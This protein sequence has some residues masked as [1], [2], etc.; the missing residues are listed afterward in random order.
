MVC[1]L[2]SGKQVNYGESSKGFERHYSEGIRVP[3]LLG[4]HGTTYSSCLQQ[5]T[6]CLLRMFA[7]TYSMSDVQIENH[8]NQKCSPGEHCEETR[9]LLYKSK[10]GMR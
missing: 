5:W 3:S 8:K 6:L 2:F 9:F 4:V 10:M 1:Y 7:E